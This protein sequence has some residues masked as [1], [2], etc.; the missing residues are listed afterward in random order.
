MASLLPNSYKPN[1]EFRYP[2][3]PFLLLLF[4]TLVLFYTPPTP[5]IPKTNNHKVYPW[6]P[7]LPFPRPTYERKL[8]DTTFSNPNS[9]CTI[10]AFMGVIIVT[11]IYVTAQ[12]LC[13]H[14][15]TYIFKM[16]KKLFFVNSH[17]CVEKCQDHIILYNC[18][19]NSPCGEL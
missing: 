3:L 9:M 18:G 12:L 19:H 6:Y 11:P 14:L 8:Y 16:S 1:L 4:Y 17:F 2:F 15:S 10:R 13:T 7:F 5:P